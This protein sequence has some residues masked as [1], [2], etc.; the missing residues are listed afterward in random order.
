[1][2]FYELFARNRD[3]SNILHGPLGKHETHTMLNTYTYT[4]DGQYIT[5][6]INVCCGCTNCV[7]L[8]AWLCTTPPQ[9]PSIWGRDKKNE[10]VRK[11]KK[12]IHAEKFGTKLMNRYTIERCSHSAHDIA[13]LVYH[14]AQVTDPRLVD[15]SIISF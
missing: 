13:S 12:N 3:A 5:I 15:N 2:R 4:H 1:M 11:V 9:Y 8:M 6:I 10:P 14:G 7:F